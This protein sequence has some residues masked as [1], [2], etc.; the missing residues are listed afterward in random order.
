MLFNGIINTS[1]YPY[2]FKDST[3]IILRKL[4]KA[5]YQDPKSYRPIALL[6]TL[7]KTLESIIATRLSYLAET[8][9]LLPPDHLG[10]RR[11]NS[12]EQAIHLL[13]ERIQTALNENQVASLLCLDVSSTFDNVS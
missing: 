11:L 1:Y 9:H 4:G 5:S 13:L 6:N 3:T 8:H 12:T 2:N 10:G 7:G